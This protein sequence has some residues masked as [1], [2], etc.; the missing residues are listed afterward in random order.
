MLWEPTDPTSPTFKSSTAGDAIIMAD[1]KYIPEG[2]L[3]D[4]EKFAR[5]TGLQEFFPAYVAE[6]GVIRENMVLLVGIGR[7]RPD[8]SSDQIEYSAKS[9]CVEDL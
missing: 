8:S 7:A 5:Q 2:I 4:E 6:G 3:S 1:A 9:L